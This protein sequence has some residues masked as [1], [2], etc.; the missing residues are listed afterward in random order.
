M[1]KT[2]IGILAV[3]LS[4]A[5]AV[6]L[7]RLAQ[8]QI[9]RYA[10]YRKLATRDRA[11]E[12]M[13]PALRGSILDRHGEIL[14]EDLPCFDISVRA[15][16]LQLRYVDV[17]AV[18]EL[19]AKFRGPQGGGDEAEQARTHLH[20]E[21]EAEFEQL[22]RRLDAE[23]FV[24]DLA[25]TLNR[26]DEEVAA[27]L[28]RA[29]HGMARGWAAARTPLR[30]VSGVEE[31]TWLG[32]RAVHEDVFMDSARLFGP[33]AAA[34]LEHAGRMSTPPFP[35]LV[36]TLSTRRVYPHG[37]LGCFALGALG[38][39]S[40]ADDEML[41]RQ[42]L[43][44]E[45]APA[46]ARFWEHLRDGVDDAAAARLEQILGADPRDIRGLRELY[47]RF[48]NL[49]PAQRETV[50]ALGLAEPLRW[51]ERPPR[52][53]LT[54][55]EM[56]WLGVGLPRSVA[57][58]MLPDHVIGEMGVERVRNQQ[59]RGKPGM[60]LRDSLEEVD[61]E[62]VFRCNSQ[63][64]PGDT[65]ALT[66][67]LAWQKAAENALK[68]QDKT[69]SIVVLDVAGGDV[70]ALASWPDF[71][72]NL[73]APP[74]DGVAREEQLRAL[75]NDPR[76]PLLNR[77][78]AEQ[79][80]LGSVMKALIAAVALEKGL[81]N[82]TETFECPGYIIEGGQKFHCDDGRAHG[83][84]NLLKAIRCSCNVTF[85][86]I[87][88]RIGVENL[89]PYARQ[90]FGRRTGIDLP[91]EA[92]GIFPDRAW[93]NQAYP[94]NP[95]LRTWTKGNDY[96]L[97]IGQGQFCATVLQATVL[98]AAVAN[99][100]YVVTPRLWLDGPAAPPRPL[101]VSQASLAVVRQGLEE[102]VNVGRP[103]ERGTAYNPFHEQG[104]PL[105]IRVAGKTSTAEHR[106][107]AEPHAWFAG[108]APADNPQ[109]AFAVMLEEGG[110]G[111][112]VAAPLAYKMLREV[113]GTQAAPVK[114]PG[115]P[116][117]NHKVAASEEH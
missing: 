90:I 29:L 76:K 4:L 95:G 89:S 3:L 43:L 62:L 113:Y 2:R 108:Y 45:N 98:M 37:S 92:A 74:R 69:G 91:G 33:G 72:P 85:Q 64:R 28:H 65:I 111:G 20:Q 35:G 40:P 78:L 57:H 109:V 34:R 52:I 27:G 30:I 117:E 18:T 42:G 26:T 32:L 79:Y 1:F 87:G 82:T 41:R 44:L 102:V 101:G 97:A 99:G 114:N 49:Q 21:R 38:E 47:S 25:R 104:P 54:E 51:S 115:G 39:L 24:K 53:E 70:L 46:R 77:A 50:A 86:Q 8:L 107:G 75:L 55:A 17:P 106:K 66:L 88:A 58:N 23:P 59:L 81:V 84:V 61:D 105:A 16:R 110:H 14:A 80:P 11:T 112:A 6:V 56:I 31:K 63:P 83:T 100:G 48:A 15:S 10:D 19:A 71:D 94:H 36:C 103:G 13:V 5:F 93:R 60:K 67:S 116:C 9:V 68:G 12:L 22:V 73:F 7:G 96:L